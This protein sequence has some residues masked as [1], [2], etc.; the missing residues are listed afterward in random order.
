MA[1]ISRFYT[2]TIAV[3]RMEWSGD[4]S[5]E[6]SQGSFSGHI[7]QM[8]AELATQLNLVHTRTFE[9]WCPKDT[10]VETGD[11][12]TIESGDYSGTYSVRATEINAQAGS[13]KHLYL[14]VEKDIIPSQ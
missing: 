7:Q 8:R 3:K 2:T 10:D 5:A 13:N 1:T 9:I 12:L 11:T 14:I 4:S 6:V